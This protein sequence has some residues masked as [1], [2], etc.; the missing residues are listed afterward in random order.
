MNNSDNLIE[1]LE[2]AYYETS[3]GEWPELQEAA[4]RIKTLEA[5]V[6]RWQELYM[7]NVEVIPHYEEPI[8]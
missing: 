4:D 2:A 7:K 8:K 3:G 6:V 5:E 1:R